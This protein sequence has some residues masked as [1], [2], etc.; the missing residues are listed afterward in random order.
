VGTG[1]VGGKRRSRFGFCSCK[2]AR[3]SRLWKLKPETKRDFWE[4]GNETR[5]TGRGLKV[6]ICLHR[7]CNSSYPKIVDILKIVDAC[8]PE[9]VIPITISTQ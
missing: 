5:K 7:R 3:F 6:N 8:L 1:G 4:G 2:G 9:S